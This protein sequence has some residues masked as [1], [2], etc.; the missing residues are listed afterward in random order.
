MRSR[1]LQTRELSLEETLQ[2]LQEPRVFT[3]FVRGPSMGHLP[4]GGHQKNSAG[5][6][7]EQSASLHSPQFLR[8]AVK[9]AAQGRIVLPFPTSHRRSWHPGTRTR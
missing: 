8:R 6:R 2:T 5:P 1:P 7:A 3:H 9:E 4:H